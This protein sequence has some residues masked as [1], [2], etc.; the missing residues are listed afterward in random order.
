MQSWR[1]FQFGSPLRL[2]NPDDFR[3]QPGLETNGAR[4]A[5]T[6]YHL[7]NP[8]AN[9]HATSSNGSRLYEGVAR[10]LTE[11]INDV[12]TVTVDADEKR[13]LFTV[14]VTDRSGTAYPARSLSDGT[15]RFLALVVLE[16]DPNA[17]GVL[18]FEEPENGVHP[19]RIPA[20]IRLLHDISVDTDQAV[21]EDNLLRQV[22]INTHSPSVVMS[23]PDSSL[24]VAESTEFMH[25]GER[26]K[27]V[28]FSPLD[29]TWRAT[30]GI[31]T[32]ARGKL[33]ADLIR[34]QSLRTGDRQSRTNQC[35][36]LSTARTC[37]N[38]CCR[39]GSRNDSFVLH[40]AYR[41][42]IRSG[43]H[44]LAYLAPSSTTML[45][46]RSSRNGQIWG[47]CRRRRA[48]YAIASTHACNSTH[49][50][51]FSF[52]ATLRMQA[53]RRVPQRLCR[54]LTR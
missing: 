24:L 9:G 2:R 35:G 7:G 16:L 14:E 52:I 6:L 27:G 53:R 34:G 37:S 19:E 17:R 43:T 30:A 31:R 39:L 42:F 48:H 44:S 13:N 25:D 26:L 40:V 54:Q 41:W 12:Y 11:L 3:T 18:C 46:A 5:A 10:R 1:L 49:V 23:V 28:S 21:S 50:T 45:G 47:A 4:L 29:D 20:I 32:V 8:K 33:L 36:A 22:I 51:C 15:L 38:C